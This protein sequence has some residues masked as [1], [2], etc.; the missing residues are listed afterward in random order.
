M[1]FL[2]VTV[3]SSEYIKFQRSIPTEYVNQGLPSS[4][5]SQIG[6]FSSCETLDYVFDGILSKCW[7]INQ[8]CSSHSYRKASD[9][10][11]HATDVRF[12]DSECTSLT[13]IRALHVIIVI[14]FTFSFVNTLIAYCKHDTLFVKMS[15]IG[16]YVS[17]LFGCVF[18]LK[19]LFGKL[20]TFQD[21]KNDD[22]LFEWDSEFDSK[23]ST[24][25]FILFYTGFGSCIL[26]LSINLLNVDRRIRNGEI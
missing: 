17:I 14:S 25:Y 23:G 16:W 9:G 12:K 22:K 10:F 19:M 7:L 5:T 21:F 15:I 2:I 13:A 11:F 8:D 20:G 3:Q 4:I 1:I 6:L 24:F 18:I 26:L